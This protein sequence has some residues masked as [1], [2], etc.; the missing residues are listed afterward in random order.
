M[1][2]Q[3]ATLSVRADEGVVAPRLKLFSGTANQALADEIAQYLGVSLGEIRITEFADG[4][5]YVRIGE[6]VRGD[7]VYIVQ[8]TCRPVNQHLIELM[9]MIDAFKRASARQVTAVIPYYGYARQDRKTAGREAIT[10]KLIANLLTHAGADRVVA[11]DLHAGQIQGFFDI[12]VDH[13]YAA[14]VLVNH[15]K[16]MDMSN[17]VIVSPDVGGV[18]R[19]RAFA[20]RLG[21]PLAIVDK[22]R[23]EPN[24]AEVL[25]VIGEVKG[26]TAIMV[27]DM[28]DTAGTLCAGAD[29]LLKE[30]AKE[31]YACATH[32]V[33][34]MPAIER[35]QNSVLKELVVT[36]SIPLAPEKRID[37]IKV[38]SVAPL[39][40][41]TIN[42]I[43]RGLSV[44]SLFD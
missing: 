10:A 38:L 22:R 8:P 31:V 1:T 15:L 19:A 39:L 23:P 28:V 40:G 42:R 18:N 26:M 32:A 36:N 21:V 29:L 17:V 2:E 14:P 44:S 41:E 27:D 20:K 5:L 37:K 35:L 4:E 25:H 33:L 11:L 16:Q 7:D 34:S 24:R 6:S 43:N 12:I 9:I 30:G 13:L 3:A